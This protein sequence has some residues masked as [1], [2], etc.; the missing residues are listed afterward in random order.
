MMNRCVDVICCADNMG[1]FEKLGELDVND[2]V[3]I[4]VVMFGYNWPRQGFII[5][6][7]LALWGSSFC[8][9]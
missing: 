3:L 8:A 9:Q 6:N 1:G 7:S 5:K 4:L 2:G